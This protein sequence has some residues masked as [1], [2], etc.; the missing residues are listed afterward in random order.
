MKVRRT[1]TRGFAALV[2]ASAAQAQDFRIDRSVI[3][4]GGG[5]STAPG[6]S[7]EGTIGQSA[8]DLLSTC[9]PD[10]GPACV[11]AAFEITSGYWVPIRSAPPTPCGGAPDCLFRSS[12]ETGDTP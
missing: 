3:A 4:S 12:F 9:S 8:A 5:V 2:L 6:Y 11:N 7:I 10:G 1:L